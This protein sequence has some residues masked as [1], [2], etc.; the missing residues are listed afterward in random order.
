[1]WGSQVLCAATMTLAVA[2]TGLWLALPW[3]SPLVLAGLLVFA[4]GWGHR[5][6]DGRWPSSRLAWVGLGA[7]VLLTVLACTISGRALLGRRPPPGEALALTFPLRGG[8]FLIASGGSNSLVNPHVATLDP[9]FRA[10]RG[11]SYAVDVVGIGVWGTRNR[12][13]GSPNPEDYA[14]FG[15]PVTAPCRG[16]VIEAWDTAPDN[17]VPERSR[18][19]IEGN[20][21]I[22]E[23]GSAWVLLAHLRSG[24]VQVS[25]G[26]EV[27]AGAPIGRVG[28]SGQSD[29]PHLHVHAQTPGTLER[30]I[31]GEPI[32]LQ[33]GDRRPVR[34]MRFHGPAHRE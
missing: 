14:I 28:N 32:P 18:D 1:M 13:I 5:R 2:L 25:K 8:P 23:C 12:R 31:S 34:N 24:S 22:L 27:E 11:Q 15:A 17:R 9:A 33:F 4:A 10:Y 6:I 30:P 20:H 7:V 26:E 29:E 21:V 3:Y 19:P 16:T